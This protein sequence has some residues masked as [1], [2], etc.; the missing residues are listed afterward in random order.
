[1]RIEIAGLKLFA[2][3]GVH[4]FERRQGQEFL[5]DITLWA[6]MQA[7]CRSDNLD[8][9]VNYSRVIDCAA[10]AFC[11]E[12]Y[13]LIER[14]AQ[15]VADAIMQDFPPITRLNIRIHKPSAPVKQPVADI[16]FEL[17]QVRGEHP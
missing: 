1:M 8:D 16:I 3:H 13:N 11:A 5:L 7:A 17:E 10:A 4:E 15:V 9:T 12:H 6:N 2:Y 14:A